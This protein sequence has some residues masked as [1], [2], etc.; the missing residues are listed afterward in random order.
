MSPPDNAGWFDRQTKAV[1]EE[2]RQW[3]AWMRRAAGI[4]SH[5]PQGDEPDEDEPDQDAANTG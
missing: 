5:P 3:P 2:I 4:E 1:N